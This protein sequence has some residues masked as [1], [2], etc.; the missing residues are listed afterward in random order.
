M[1]DQTSPPALV[2]EDDFGLITIFAKALEMAGFEV[3]AI[4]DGGEALQYLKTTTP[5]VI[6]LDLHLPTLSGIEIFNYFHTKTRFSKTRVIIA[7]ADLAAANTLGQ[8]VDL[9]LVKPISFNQLRDLAMR[10]RQ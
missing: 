3:K 10:L 7:T 5:E 9:V 4:T 1:N 6:V 2:I 8:D